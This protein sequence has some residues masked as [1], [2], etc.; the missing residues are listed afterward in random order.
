M[1]VVVSGPFQV[2]EDIVDSLGLVGQQGEIYSAPRPD[3]I[4]TLRRYAS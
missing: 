4:S 1:F 3:S 2:G